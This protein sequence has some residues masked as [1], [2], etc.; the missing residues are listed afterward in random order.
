M[1]DLPSQYTKFITPLVIMTF[2]KIF[3]RNLY[4]N[5]RF[6]KWLF[7]N[8]HSVAPVS[9]YLIKW[10]ITCKAHTFQKAI[11]FLHPPGSGVKRIPL[12]AHGTVASPTQSHEY[13]CLA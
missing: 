1:A 3:F 10:T 12:I 13:L 6:K 9:F 5:V 2:K 11:N 8:F 7:N 4:K